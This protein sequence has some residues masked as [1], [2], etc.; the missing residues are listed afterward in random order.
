MST[1]VAFRVGQPSTPY[2]DGDRK[3]PRLGRLGDAVVSQFRGRY[4]EATSRGMVYHFSQLV[5][6]DTLPIFS[7]TAQKYGLRNP[8]GSG[9]ALELIRLEIG[10]L[11]AAQAPGNL[12]F[13]QA[14]VSSATIATG[15]GGI[16]AATQ[17]AG[18]CGAYGAKTTASKC[19]M[20]TTITSVAPTVILRTL[21]FSMETAVAA[22]T[23]NNLWQVVEFNGTDIL[24]PDQILLLACTVAAGIGVDIINMIAMEVPI[25]PGS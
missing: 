24:Y 1:D 4:G 8:A 22:G 11:S 2:S 7:N 3:E 21:G 10:Y 23:N 13:C 19:T 25:P 18:L 12:V 17:T 5:A 15:S 16:T 14:P 20:L 9:V 6:G